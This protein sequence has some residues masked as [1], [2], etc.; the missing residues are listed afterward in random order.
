MTKSK[1]GELAV[2]NEQLDKAVELLKEVVDTFGEFLSLTHFH[3]LIA[4]LLLQPFMSLLQIRL[5]FC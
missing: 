1:L 4:L 3:L 2:K 5:L